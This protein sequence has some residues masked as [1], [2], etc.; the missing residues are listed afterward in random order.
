MWEFGDVVKWLKTL[1]HPPNQK[2]TT[3]SSP[4]WEGSFHIGKWRGSPSPFGN[5]HLFVV[6]FWLEEFGIQEKNREVH[7][8]T[9]LRWL[10][11]FLMEHEQEMHWQWEGRWQLFCFHFEQ[12]LKQAGCL[13]QHYSHNI[14][15]VAQSVFFWTLFHLLGK[16]HVGISH[17]DPVVR[18]F[19]QGF[20]WVF[21]KIR[22][23]QNGW[24]TM[25]H[26]IKMDD[27]GY[28]YFWKHH[29]TN[30]SPCSCATST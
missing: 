21:P 29:I 17:S 4:C 1:W 5:M 18:G 14:E 16:I 15:G 26:P 7:V 3:G 22:V 10:G 28:P 30:S 23:P 25:E 12:F 24:F 8:V 11:F 19:F 6:I 9:G 2:T 27:L 20:I 13:R